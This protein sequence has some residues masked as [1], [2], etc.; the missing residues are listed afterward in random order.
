MIY[1]EPSNGSIFLPFE[2]AVNSLLFPIQ[3]NTSGKLT[4]KIVQFDEQVLIHL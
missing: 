4:S 3:L 2:V 1:S